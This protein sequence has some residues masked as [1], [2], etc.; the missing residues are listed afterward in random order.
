M[1][2]LKNKGG[3]VFWFGPPPILDGDGN[4][5]LEQWEAIFG[6]NYTSE[7]VQGQIAVGKRI[8]F[9]NQLE[10][11]PSQFILTDF[12]V[13]RIYPVKAKEGTS[14]IGLL[15]QYVVDWNWK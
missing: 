12:L 14:K 3:K 15:R 10:T 1:N 4:S 11:V 5:C 13:D 9:A 8:D 7:K 6:V 2:D